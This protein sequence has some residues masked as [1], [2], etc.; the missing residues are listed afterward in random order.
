MHKEPGEKRDF[1]PNFVSYIARRRT[2]IYL[3]Y[4][5]GAELG[6]RER[7]YLKGNPNIKFVSREEVYQQDYV[8]VLRCPTEIEIKT[9][10]PGSCLI[11]MLHYPTR[12]Q[13]IELIRSQL[14]E[15]ISLDSITDDSGRRLVENLKAVGWNGIEV[16]FNT[17]K[18]IYPDPGFD[19]P[20]RPPIR[21]TVMGAGAVGSHVVQAAIRYGNNNLR[22][23]L[24]SEDIPGVEVVVVDHDVTNKKGYMVKILSK[25]DILV[26]AT[27]RQDTSKPVIPNEWIAYLPQH[28]VLLDLSV[29]PYSESN[30]KI[31]LK[32]I[33]GIP[34]GNLNKYI[35][36]PDDRAYD[37]L[38]KY[39]KTVNRRH[40]V[41][42]YSWPGIYPKECMRVYG[43]Q[44]QPLMRV[45][46]EKDG[47][48]K[49]NPKG[50]FFERALS[51]AVLSRWNTPSIIN[52]QSEVAN[53]S[54][55]D[56]R[57]S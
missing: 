11:S 29:D 10:H 26:D 53:G 28:A 30:G 7:D 27:Q 47:V 50:G 6:Y 13:R 51:R 25:T 52:T 49:L 16:S 37:E 38:P 12:P 14:L 39:V 20:N 24:A 33:E 41:T 32:G 43:R 5:Y 45:L 22:E 17:L 36:L 19:N 1:L 31:T 21:V 42:C 48:K 54:T 44:I 57:F 8:L 40:A 18:T 2:D 3:E 55:K 23:K 46:M 35:F 56:R 4:G 9:M 15:A 34:Q